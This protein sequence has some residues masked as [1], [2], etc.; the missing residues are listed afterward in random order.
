[1]AHDVAMTTSRPCAIALR[2]SCSTAIL[3]RWYGSIGS[4]GLTA[5]VS[6]LGR[7]GTWPTALNEPVTTTRS[8]P[9]SSAARSRWR[10]PSTFDS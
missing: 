4:K 8:T 2:H 7:P 5:S 1:M 10:V 6:S 3:E 9:A